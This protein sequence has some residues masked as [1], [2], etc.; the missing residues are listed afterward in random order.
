[1]PDSLSDE[2]D[3]ITVDV[4]RGEDLEGHPVFETLLKFSSHYKPL[5]I[6][7]QY[8]V[9]KSLYDGL[10]GKQPNI[11]SLVT[12]KF[13]AKVN[14]TTKLLKGF[15]MN[16]ND[17]H[18]RCE[19][20]NSWMKC[21]IR[22]FTD[23]DVLAQEMVVVFFC[24]DPEHELDC[25]VIK[26]LEEGQIAGNPNARKK[27]TAQVSFLGGNT[28]NDQ[29]KSSQST[30]PSSSNSSSGRFEP[31]PP[32]LTSTSTSSSSVGNTHKPLIDNNNGNV[33]NNGDSSDRSDT[34]SPL[35]SAV[36]AHNHDHGIDGQHQ[37]GIDA[38]GADADESYEDELVAVPEVSYQQ[39]MHAFRNRN[40]FTSQSAAAVSTASVSIPTLSPS[41]KQGPSVSV[42]I[43]PPS[44]GSAASSSS[45]SSN[46]TTNEG[47]EDLIHVEV[48]RGAD[49]D[50]HPT[51]ETSLI[52]SPHFRPI[53]VCGQYKVYKGQ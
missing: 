1:M 18:E 6:K 5:I 49:N 40:S 41:A 53:M 3:L 30:A 36:S 10:V 43:A 21:L 20:L 19:L 31:V 16:E 29:M 42:S 4:C 24:L 26:M 7:G 44:S 17:L 2:Y 12:E 47:R 28:S 14:K 13:P 11:K 46:S 15:Q 37:P 27:P 22:R 48:N 9:Y 34:S 51:Y 32:P 50:G 25:H 8:K 52:F 38:S 33:S 35:G 39:A 23:L 45:T